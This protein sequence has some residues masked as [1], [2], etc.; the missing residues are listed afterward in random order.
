M[1]LHKLKALHKHLEQSNLVPQEKL[2][3]W[4]ENINVMPSG[5]NRGNGS[6]KICNTEYTAIFSLENYSKDAALVIAIL[7]AWLFENDNNRNADGLGN[8]SVEVDIEDDNSAEITIEI[9]FKEDITLV[10]DANGSINLGGTKYS[11]A[12]AEITVVEDSTVLG[13]GEVQP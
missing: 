3:S 13:A 9:K 6:V 8:P 1:F 12:E 10:E 2:D 4:A 7:S 5:K 11:V